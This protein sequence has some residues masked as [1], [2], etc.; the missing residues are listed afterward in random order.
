MRIV[1]L[2]D[3]DISRTKGLMHR[4]PLGIDECAFFDFPREG[5]HCFWNKNVGFPISLIFC[6]ASGKVLDIKRLN[7]QQTTTIKPD[8]YNVKYVVEAHI[9][10]PIKFKIRKGGQMV[11]GEKEVFFK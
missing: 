5:Q 9:D 7:A 8:V 6:G 10:A 4:D 1:L 3:N 11:K 2:A